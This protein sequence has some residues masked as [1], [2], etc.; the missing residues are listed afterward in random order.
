MARERIHVQA[1]VA[2]IFARRWSP[3]AFD[4]ARPVARAALISALEAA[5]W[6]PSCYGDQPWRFIIAERATDEDAWRGVFDALA[7]ANQEWAGQAPL[8]VVAAAQTRFRHNDA[9]NRWH[10]YDCGQAML[11]FCLQASALGLVCHQMGGFD[12]DA[13]RSALAIPASVALMSVTAVGHP[14]DAASLSESLQGTER[15]P[16]GR[17]PLEQ[18]AFAGRWERPLDVPRALGW[19]ARYEESPAEKLPWFHDRLDEDFARA[20]DALGIE[21]GRALDLGCGPGTQ[22]IALAGRGF[23]VT[24]CD[25]APAAIDGARARAEECGVAVDFRIADATTVRFDAPFDLVI[26]RGVL[27]CFDDPAQRTRYIESIRAAL[28]PGGVLLLKC[29]SHEEQREEGPPCRFAPEQ[30]RAFFADGF[31]VERIEPARFAGT[32]E[33]EQPKALFAVI[34]RD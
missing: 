22:A 13:I 12:A 11:S 15:A 33:G 16:R 18:I 32:M 14:G 6:A 8:F 17:L 21:G 34:R 23:A 9:P 7:P 4:P 1:P 27:H 20:L 19:Q 28:R 30:L 26:D 5:R 10:G 25:V 29:F 24:A 3:R 2:P 31:T